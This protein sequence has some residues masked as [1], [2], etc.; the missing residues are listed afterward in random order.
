[1][2][3]LKQQFSEIVNENERLLFKVISIY[4]RS[5]DEKKDLYQ[6]ILLQ[7]W[8]ALPS[9]R[10]KS[11][12]STWIYR[13]A[14][15][16]SMNYFRK[17]P[18]TKAQEFDFSSIPYQED[19]TILKDQME[20]MYRTINRLNSFE[21]ALVLLYLEGKSYAEISEISGISKT[22]VG[23]RLSRIKEKLKNKIKTS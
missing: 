23:T 13:I 7:L 8:K 10:N 4:S 9:F 12:T 2:E 14:L 15:N 22:N 1:M 18:L 19:D 21:K 11:K 5:E 17:K 20:A 16:V 3:Q 6:E